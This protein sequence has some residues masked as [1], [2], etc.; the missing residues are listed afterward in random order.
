MSLETELAVNRRNTLRFIAARPFVLQLVPSISARTETGGTAF[1]DG[2][3]RS[4]QTLR[5][6]EQASAYGN[7]PGLLPAQ[8]GKQRRVRYQLLGGYDATIA[9]GDHWVDGNGVRFE[10]V[11][12]LPYNGYE[13]RGQVVQYG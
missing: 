10:V 3:L 6:I 7:S 9:V 8:D 1:S 11:E 13:R 12:L 5:L 4:A 2:P